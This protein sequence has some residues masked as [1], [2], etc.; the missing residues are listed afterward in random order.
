MRCLDNGPHLERSDCWLLL[1]QVK[2]EWSN[3]CLYKRLEE[4]CLISMVLAKCHGPFRAFSPIVPLLIRLVFFFC[5]A[6]YICVLS[7]VMYLPALDPCKES[8][9]EIPMMVWCGGLQKVSGVCVCFCGNSF[10]GL[11]L[12]YEVDGE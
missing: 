8:E 11:N 9:A 10:E 4:S 12:S 1:F 2:R 3:S 5:S 6:S 7:L